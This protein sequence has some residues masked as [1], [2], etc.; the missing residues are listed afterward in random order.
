LILVDDLHEYG[1]VMR[2]RKTPSCHM[3]SDTSPEEL[4]EFAKSIGL[5]E[6]WFQD[7]A[8]FPH[9]DLTPSKRAKAIANGAVAVSGKTLVVWAFRPQGKIP[10]EIEKARILNKYPKPTGEKEMNIR[11]KNFRS[12]L[13]LIL[14]RE[15]GLCEE[16]AGDWTTQFEDYELIQCLELGQSPREFIQ[17]EYW[18][19]G[20]RSTK[21]SIVD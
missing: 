20:F 17:I 4:I 19:A 8:K 9:F 14:V 16:D 21:P 5:R 3:V 18:L 15:K 7:P 11:I 13:G 12:E 6:T 1:W 10:S 2:G